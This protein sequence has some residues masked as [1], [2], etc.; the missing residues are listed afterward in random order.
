ML[1][2]KLKKEIYTQTSFVY[3]FSNIYFFNVSA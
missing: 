1:R 2:P 3:I